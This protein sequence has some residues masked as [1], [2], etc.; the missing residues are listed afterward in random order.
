MLLKMLKYSNVLQ[1]LKVGNGGTANGNN[2]VSHFKI[3][4]SAV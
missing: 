2:V 1:S 3:F 4:L